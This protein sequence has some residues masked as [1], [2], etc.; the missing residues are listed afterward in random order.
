MTFSDRQIFNFPIL[1]WGFSG[2]NLYRV[3]NCT[4]YIEWNLSGNWHREWK[5][6][7]IPILHSL[8][9][10]ISKYIGK[11]YRLVRMNSMI[12]CFTAR[13]YLQHRKLF[14]N[15]CGFFFLLLPCLSWWILCWSSF[16]LSLFCRMSFCLI[17][18]ERHLRFVYV[19][20]SCE[21]NPVFEL[22]LNLIGI[23]ILFGSF[24]S[25][26]AALYECWRRVEMCVCVAYITDWAYNRIQ[27]N[28]LNS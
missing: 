9:T 7:R 26:C 6:K 12:Y 3:Y 14:Q 16:Y 24:R 25:L 10:N 13:T 23:R 4:T 28:C 20:A 8:N 11:F 17:R 2:K 18:F 27:M 21:K 19:H 5:K 1:L 22:W 15:F